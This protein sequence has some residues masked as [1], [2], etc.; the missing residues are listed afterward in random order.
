MKNSVVLVLSAVVLLVALQQC[1]AATRG[2]LKTEAVEADNDLHVS[3][4]CITHIKST[5]WPNNEEPNLQSLMRLSS[6]GPMILKKLMSGP[7]FSWLNEL[8]G[9][10]CK[11]LQ[12]LG[13]DTTQ[14]KNMAKMTLNSRLLCVLWWRVHYEILRK[15]FLEVDGLLCHSEFQG[16][17]VQNKK[18]VVIGKDLGVNSSPERD[19]RWVAAVAKARLNADVKRLIGKGRSGAPN[20][21]KSTVLAGRYDDAVEMYTASIQSCKYN[22]TAYANRANTFMRLHRFEEA[23]EDCR[24]A[25]KLSPEYIKAHYYLGQCLCEL[26]SY[27]KGLWHLQESLRICQKEGV[28][29]MTFERT[30]KIKLKN[31]RQHQLSTSEEKKKLGDAIL[32]TRLV[33]IV[34]ADT[35]RKIQCLKDTPVTSRWRPSGRVS[36]KVLQEQISNEE[37]QSQ[38]LLEWITKAFEKLRNFKEEKHVVPE[39]MCCKI[40][41]CLMR[42]PVITPCGITYERRSIVEHLRRGNNFDPTTRQPLTEKELVTNLA[43]REAIEEFLS[44]NEWALKDEDLNIL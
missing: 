9:Y 5:L 38:K 6:K 43:L 36:K 39:Y 31:W 28:S 4:T 20:A 41:L 42:D 29:R 7:C 16:I 26:G 21:G 15:M 40:S 10:F 22:P 27:D 19:S 32:Q 18:E 34:L 35:E 12:M 33:D 30:I 13:I 24:V 23:V 25:I 2:K 1:D 8:F 11:F 17:K 3:G 44:Q 37:H 14:V